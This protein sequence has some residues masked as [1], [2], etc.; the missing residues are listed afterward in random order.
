MYMYIYTYIYIYIYI[1]G[2]KSKIKSSIVGDFIL[3]DNPPG[4]LRL[5]LCIINAIHSYYSL[6]SYC[7]YLRY[8]QPVYLH[9][10]YAINITVNPITDLFI[11]Y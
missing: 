5:L 7:L 4:L 10:V 2:G 3:L 9:L 6:N 11:Y 1:E 8:I